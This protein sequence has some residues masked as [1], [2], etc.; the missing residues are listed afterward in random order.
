MREELPPQLTVGEGG[1]WE[2]L[3]QLLTELKGVRE[4]VSLVTYFLGANDMSIPSARQH[5][6]RPTE[7]P[8]C[9]P[10]APQLGLCSTTSTVKAFLFH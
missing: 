7:F 3:P 1:G 6:L 4:R 5:G 2:G 10:S 8:L 9:I